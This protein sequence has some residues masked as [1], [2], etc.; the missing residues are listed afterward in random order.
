MLSRSSRSEVFCKIGTLKKFVKFTRKHM[1]QSVLI[2]LQAW[3]CADQKSD[4]RTILLL[5]KL[6][7]FNVLWTRVKLNQIHFDFKKCYF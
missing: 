5:E 2:K 6:K 4:S 7:H 3:G 1:C